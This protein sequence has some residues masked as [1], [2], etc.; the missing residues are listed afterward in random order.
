MPP[1]PHPKIPGPHSELPSDG[2]RARTRA[3]MLAWPSASE[4][5]S[6]LQSA[7]QALSALEFQLGGERGREVVGRPKFLGQWPVV[8]LI[9]VPSDGIG[10]MMKSRGLEIPALCL[11]YIGIQAKR[12]RHYLE[13]SLLLSFMKLRRFSG[14]MSKRERKGKD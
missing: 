2:Q 5:R 7:V 11:G 1:L 8:E 9:G 14:S 10:L 13:A 3:P 6:E 4:L 12:S